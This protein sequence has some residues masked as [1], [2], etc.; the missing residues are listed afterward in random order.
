MVDG[1][2]IKF[3]KCVLYFANNVYYIAKN[4]VRVYTNDYE[5]RNEM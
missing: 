1:V 3:A 2:L 5:I 4:K